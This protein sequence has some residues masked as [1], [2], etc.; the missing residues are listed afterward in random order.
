[1][2]SAGG[3]AERTEALLVRAR[4]SGY[5]GL[6]LTIDNQLIGKRERDLAN[7]R[8]LTQGDYDVVWV[9]DGDGEFAVN[10]P[11]RT[12]LPRPVVVRRR[13]CRE[14]WGQ[15]CWRWCVV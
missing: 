1:M 11:Y 8:L 10:L 2:G 15:R 7:P 14:V 5:Q 6:I 9:V 13:H 12:L 4:A 3:E